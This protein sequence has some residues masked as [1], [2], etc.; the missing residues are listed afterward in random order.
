VGY[1]RTVNLLLLNHFRVSDPY[2]R[3]D[4]VRACSG[5][6]LALAKS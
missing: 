3:R 4:A 2:K 1:G 6:H 5:C